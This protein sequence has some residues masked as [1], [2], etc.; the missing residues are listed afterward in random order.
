MFIIFLILPATVEQVTILENVSEDTKVFLQIHK[1]VWP[2]T[3]RDALFWSHKRQVPDPQDPDGQSIW[4]VCN[5]S[6]D[7]KNAPVRISFVKKYMY[8]L[9]KQ[10]F[11]K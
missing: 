5:N 9:Q 1:R 4:I 11:Q 3:Q 2:S 10:N 6:T 7:H 8:I